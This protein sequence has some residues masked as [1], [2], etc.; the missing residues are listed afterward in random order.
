MYSYRESPLSKSN[1]VRCNGIISFLSDAVSKVK[2][3]RKFS[4]PDLLVRV[5]V[6]LR[7][8]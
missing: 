1:A 2:D 6:I 5:C 3:M 8:N 4:F 7:P